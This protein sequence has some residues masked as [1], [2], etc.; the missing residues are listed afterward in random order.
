M[1]EAG[2]RKIK[3]Y[4]VVLN[5]DG[6]IA[7]NNLKKKMALPTNQEKPAYSIENRDPGSVW[8]GIRL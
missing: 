6:S 8:M 2:G 7:I 1:S 5:N 4:D 3:V